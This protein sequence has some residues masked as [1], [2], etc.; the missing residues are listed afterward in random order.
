MEAE[1]TSK[2]VWVTSAVLTKQTGDTAIEMANI[3]RVEHRAKTKEEAR[4]SHVHACARRT[5]GLVRDVD[6]GP[7][8]G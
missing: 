6:R 7:V 2:G 1:H 4:G 5:P 3:V 8:G